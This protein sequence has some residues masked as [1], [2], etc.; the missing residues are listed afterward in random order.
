MHGTS[1]DKAD[2]PRK[3]QNQVDPDVAG[4]NDTIYLCNFRV[5]VDGEWLCLKE[6]QDMDMQDS[7]YSQSE[8]V[9]S[10]QEHGPILGTQNLNGIMQHD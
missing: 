2:L 5:S 10:P 9:I 3:T 8:Q 7:T 6:L 4:A 1:L